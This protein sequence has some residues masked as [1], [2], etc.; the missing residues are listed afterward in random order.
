MVGLSPTLGLTTVIMLLLA[1]LLRLNYVATQIGIHLMTPLQ[2]VLFLP[3]IDVGIAVFRAEPLPMSRDEILGLM[4]HH[5]IRLM[6]VLWQW[7]WHALAVWA[8]C[9]AVC[10]PILAVQIRKVL[11][12]SMRRHEDLLA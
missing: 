12:M 4:H 11:E 8:V 7:E 5:P 1:W 2:V 10:T 9:A 3:L 6:H